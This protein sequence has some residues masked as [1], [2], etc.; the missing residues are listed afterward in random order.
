MITRSPKLNLKLVYQLQPPVLS[1]P[2][3][4]P[5]LRRL[6]LARR[7]VF[8]ERTD[9]TRL[10]N[11]V[12]EKWKISAPVCISLF[13]KGLVLG[14]IISRMKEMWRSDSL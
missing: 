2:E 10:I 13:Q 6:R 9:A 3:V 14:A 12:A 7:E 8:W 11:P 5:Q 4:G 1:D